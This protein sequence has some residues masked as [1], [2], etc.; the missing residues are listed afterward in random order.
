MP[1]VLI[2]ADALR[3]QPGFFRE[4]LISAGFEPVDP[5]GDHTLTEPELLEWLPGCSAIVAGGEP[6]T[7][8]VMDRSAGLRV[9]AR[10]G[11][12]YDRVDV[13]AATGHRVAVTITP[14]TNHESVAEQAFALLLA[15][16]RRICVNDRSIR[17]GGWDRTLPIP[18]R[19]KSLGLVGL[20]RIGRAMVPRARA[21]GMRVQGFD[22]AISPAEA[23]ELGVRLLDLEELV[24]ESDVISLHVPVTDQ[25][26]RMVNRAWLDRMKA[27]SILL[28]SSRGGLVDQSAL[29]EALESGHLAGAGLDVTDPEPPSPS[30]PLLQAPTLV[31]SPH[32]GG[33]DTLA[34][35]AMAESAAQSIVDLFKGEWPH[36]KVVN[37]SI[38]E[39]WAW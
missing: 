39:G 9:I 37:D 18:L 5:P 10:V 21:F 33:I 30:E 8:R 2:G 32:L 31:L 13:P 20:G 14:G 15:V 7:A 28:N 6:L 22:P 17:A 36:G 38:S 35:A 24:E 3:S 4:R 26:S 11:V 23:E 27:G 29:L 25:T 34:L 12:G 16:T 19:G 1:R